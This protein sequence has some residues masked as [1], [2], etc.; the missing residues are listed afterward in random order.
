MCDGDGIFI[1]VHEII[2]AI[3]DDLQHRPGDI[4]KLVA[5]LD[6]GWDV[7]Y[8]RPQ[9]LLTGYSA[10]LIKEEIGENAVPERLAGDRAH[11]RNQ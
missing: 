4:P 9:R 11:L 1:N 5:A 6:E 2:I 10:C 8:G 3:D 7:V